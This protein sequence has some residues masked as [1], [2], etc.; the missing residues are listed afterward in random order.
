MDNLSIWSA[1]SKTDPS[2]TKK[3][4][5]RGGFTAISAHYQVM[6]ATEQFGP[7]GIGWG[8]EN[9]EPIFHDSLVFVP[10]T[11]W[12]GTRD[13]KFGPLYG[14]AEWKSPK[15]FVDSDAPKKAATDGLTK[16]L[17]HLGFNA[18]VFLGMFDD[19][20]YVAAMQREFSGAGGGAGHSQVDAVNP[21]AAD[22]LNGAVNQA[23][24]SP[25]AGSAEWPE[26]PAKNKAEV[27]TQW[28]ALK[29]KILDAVEA[30]DPDTLDGHL[31][32]EKA[33]LRQIEIVEPRWW[34][35]EGLPESIP[36]FIMACQA[37]AHKNEASRLARGP[38][39]GPNGQTITDAG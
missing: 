26:G 39:V 38:M 19:N 21:P 3:V 28:A 5:Q 2:H 33:L 18:D 27:R 23:H 7:V 36:G 31:A 25:R 24:A 1:V 12:H 8:Y 34:S 32:D 29:A 30:G 35:G 20:K 16:A 14:G 15:G 22:K 11:V 6:R 13:N 4:N 10:V 9:G 37:E 17:S